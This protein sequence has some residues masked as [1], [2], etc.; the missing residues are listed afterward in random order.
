M[1]YKI[2]IIGPAWI[3]DT[4]MAQSLF[5]LLKENNPDVIIDV[6]APGWSLSLL[7][8]M[9]EVRQGISMP[10]GHGQFALKKRWELGK[11][12]RKEN[13][14]RAIV[15]PNSWKS[16]IIPF[17]AKIPVRTGWIGEV[18]FGLLNDIRYLN[19]KKLPLMVERFIAL[20]LSKNSSLPESYIYPRLHTSKNSIVKTFQKLNIASSHPFIVIC[21]GAEF[22]PAKRW[23]SEH[24]A[25]LADQI[26]NKFSKDAEVIILGSQKDE[27]VAAEICRAMHFPCM[28]LTGKTTLE[29]ALDILSQSHAVISNDSGLMHIAASFE[30]PLVVLYG[31]SSP[32]FT[33]PLSNKVKMLSL[34]LPCSPC[35]KR[36]CP[37][38]HLNCLR[39]ISPDVVFKAMEEIMV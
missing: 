6:S 38:E 4:V 21:P 9:P 29:E 36:E 16:A 39:G 11:G 37:L 18:R 28:N 7:N 34:D 32:R 8:R 27:E 5:K 35:F 12:L 30:I 26:K 10:L 31:S 1:A 22:G 23:P 19:K 2:L 33:P 25:A 13:Y 3:G 17:A 24:F 14:N 20:G 15:L